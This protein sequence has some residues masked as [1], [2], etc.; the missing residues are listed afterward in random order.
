M[1]TNEIA[2]AVAIIREYTRIKEEA[3][4]IIEAQ[5]AAIRE[6]MTAAALEDISGTDYK[7]S[8]HTVNGTKLDTA[9]LKKAHPEIYAAY[10][11]PN[12][13]KRLLIS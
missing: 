12:P 5:K 9:N 2:A 1:S 11:K 6:H 13:Y 10:N 3:E 7:I 8:Y 4:A